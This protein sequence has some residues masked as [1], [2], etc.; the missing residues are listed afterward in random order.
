MEDKTIRMGK[1]VLSEKPRKQIV[2]VVGKNT[3]CG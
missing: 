1:W 2:E 3:L